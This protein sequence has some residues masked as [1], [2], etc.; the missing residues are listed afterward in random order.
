MKIPR[1]V[2]VPFCWLAGLCD[3]STGV[4]LVA[5]PLFT[6]RLMNIDAMPAEPVYMRF[7]GAFVAS[8]GFCYLVP[9]LFLRGAMRDRC[10]EGMLVT[11]MV[12]RLFIATFTGIAIAR[13]ALAASWITVPLSD[14][15][16]ASIQ[17]VLLKQ[18]VF[19][20]SDA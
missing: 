13:G 6:L 16:L 17:F 3:F 4:M 9:F 20:P 12:I 19:G 5:A 2:A 8:A 1:T 18:R 14:L 15:T 7:I 10:V 11:T